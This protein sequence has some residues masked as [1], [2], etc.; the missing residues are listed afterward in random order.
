MSPELL[1]ETLDAT[2]EEVL[3]G[4]KLMANTNPGSWE[5]IHFTFLIEGV[6]RAF[7]QQLTRTRQ[8]SYAQQSFR[9]VEIKDFSYETGPTI[10][11]DATIVGAYR[12]TMDNA[13]MCYKFL[14]DAG[15]NVEDARGVLPLNTHTNI[16]MSINMRNFISTARKRT[17]GRVQSEYRGVIDACLIEIEKVYPWFYIFYKQD[18]IKAYKDLLDMLYENEKL[19]A[20]EKV[21]MYRKIDIMKS[22]LE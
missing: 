14:I 16:C 18:Q 11:S 4:L 12:N 1:K 10:M 13:F 5:F 7:C 3:L 9:V 15:V 8:A 21:A 6:T 2:D 17:S 19:T 22:G 20:D